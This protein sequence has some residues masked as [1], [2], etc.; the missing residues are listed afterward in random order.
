ML[1]SAVPVGDYF[2]KGNARLHLIGILGGAIWNPGMSFSIIASTA[3]DP[4]LAYGLGQRATMMAC[5]GPVD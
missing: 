2:R 3:A 1:F 5:C 4:A